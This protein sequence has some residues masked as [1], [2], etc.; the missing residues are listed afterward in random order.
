[1]RPGHLQEHFGP[2][3]TGSPI[4]A[5]PAP[6]A[7]PHVLDVLDKSGVWLFV[8]AVGRPA[9]THDGARVVGGYNLEPGRSWARPAKPIIEGCNGL[10]KPSF[11]GFAIV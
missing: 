11:S 3:G 8:A 7:S 6:N 2:P 9:I 10:R 5:G 1:M 4:W